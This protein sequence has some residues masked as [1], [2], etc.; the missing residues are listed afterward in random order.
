MPQLV[1]QGS[2]LLALEPDVPG[3]GSAG[4]LRPIGQG[5]PGYRFT[6]GPQAWVVAA[7]HAAHERVLYNRLLK[8]LRTGVGA[9][10]PLLMPQ[11]VDGEPSLMAARSAPHA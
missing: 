5:G 8:R 11:A 9:S 7:Q 10:Q 1:V 4:V 3:P 6:E 2:A